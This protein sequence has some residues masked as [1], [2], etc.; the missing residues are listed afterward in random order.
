MNRHDEQPTWQDGPAARVRLGV[1]HHSEEMRRAA[2]EDAHSA[3]RAQGHGY[4]SVLR[5]SGGDKARR[6]E[7]KQEVA[8][9][10][11]T[12]F[13]CRL[14][15]EHMIHDAP[16][17]RRR[18]IVQIGKPR[19]RHMP[20]SAGFHRC[21]FDNAFQRAF[22]DIAYFTEFAAKCTQRS[23]ASPHGDERFGKRM[24]RRSETAYIHD[25][26]IEPCGFIRPIFGCGQIADIRQKRIVETMLAM[27]GV[28]VG[29]NPAARILNF[30]DLEVD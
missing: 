11:Q 10:H 3:N 28:A 8:G 5:R 26:V 25:Y 27:F 14:C 23:A 2:E 30:C 4:E 21:G 12:A 6:A 9:R 13:D 16:A 24:L 17:A 20:H 29:R 15:V 22:P 18:L 1:H 19:Q 7:C